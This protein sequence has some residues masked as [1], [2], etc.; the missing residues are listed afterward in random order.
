MLD[1]L[2]LYLKEHEP[3]GRSFNPHQEDGVIGSRVG[4]TTGP[5]E[6]GVDQI[7]QVV[8]RWGKL[9]IWFV[10]TFKSIPV[11]NRLNRCQGRYFRLLVILAS[12]VSLTRY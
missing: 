4:Q 7:V 10:I 2:S 5:I 11:R 1:H 12:A 9:S 6:E 8:H 3:W